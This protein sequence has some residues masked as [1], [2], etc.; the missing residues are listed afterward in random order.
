MSDILTI[1]SVFA[2]GNI[3]RFDGPNDRRAARVVAESRRVRHVED[4]SREGE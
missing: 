2:D 4:S 1:E 3:H